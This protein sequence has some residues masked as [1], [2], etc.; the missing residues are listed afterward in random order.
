MIQKSG[1][2]KSHKHFTKTEK[3]HILTVLANNDG[4]LSKTGRETGA[5][6]TTIRKWRNDFILAK[7]KLRRTDT[8]GR[9]LANDLEKTLTSQ[10]KQPDKLDDIE[11]E[12]IKGDV[13]LRPDRNDVI[14]AVVITD[15]VPQETN[16]ALK[17][18]LVTYHALLDKIA[19]MLPNERNMNNVANAIK[20]VSPVIL[21]LAKISP[22]DQPKTQGETFY[23]ALTN[24]LIN[25]KKK[26]QEEDGK[27]SDSPD[28]SK[29]TSRTG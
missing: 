4:N 21:A 8:T 29:S 20:S 6:L 26:E 11:I 18:S 1:K 2:K 12:V 7:D 24:Y 17:K 15:D 28:K 16:K 5:S 13:Q 10:L 25:K 23:D 27:T 9:K 14:D 22:D 3:R 19:V